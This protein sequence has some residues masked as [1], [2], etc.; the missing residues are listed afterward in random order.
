MGESH[1]QKRAITGKQAEAGAHI[2]LLI[3]NNEGKELHEFVGR[4]YSTAD[5]SPVVQGLTAPE[6]SLLLRA[7][8]TAHNRQMMVGNHVKNLVPSERRS[9]EFQ[10]AVSMQKN[11]NHLYSKLILLGYELPVSDLELLVRFEAENLNYRNARKLIDHCEIRGLSSVNYE[12][13]KLQ[14][15]GHTVP[16]VWCQENSSQ[17]LTNRRFTTEAKEAFSKVLNDFSQSSNKFSPNLESHKLVMGGFAHSGDLTQVRL[18]I[19]EI[20]GVPMDDSTPRELVAVSSALY[21][22]QDLLYKIIQFFGYR[23]ASLEGLEYVLK[24]MH[25]YNIDVR[26]YTKLWR[27]LISFIQQE[28]KGDADLIASKFNNVW[29]VM[30]E[31][32]VRLSSELFKKRCDILSAVNREDEFMKDLPT[33]KTMCL[34]NSSKL[35]RLRVEKILTQYLKCSALFIFK[36]K[37]DEEE[38]HRLAIGYFKQY[39]ISPA[40]L[41]LLQASIPELQEAVQFQRQKFE[42]LQRQYDEEDDE[43]SLW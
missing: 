15:L 5:W 36:S 18:H 37:E 25:Y 3:Q 35:L 9:T 32:N 28:S 14:V 43:G 11:V 10:L 13:L 31:N 34:N 39:S 7:L 16:E 6:V 42:E 33:L 24:F 30:L 8:V 27:E 1:P 4:M 23:R 17:T 26:R 29:E 41:E 19:N 22:D 21:P 20:W 38:A 12:N 2:R 40:H